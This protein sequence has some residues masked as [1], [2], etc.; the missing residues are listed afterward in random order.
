MAHCND[1]HTEF[2]FFHFVGESG[3]WRWTT[4]VWRMSGDLLKARVL[5]PHLIEKHRLISW[6]WYKAHISSFNL[7]SVDIYK[8]EIQAWHR[9]QMYN[10][11]CLTKLTI[12][13]PS[14]LHCEILNYS[15][16]LTE[17][18]P[19]LVHPVDVPA[20]IVL[21]WA[22]VQVVVALPLKYYSNENPLKTTKEE[23]LLNK[24]LLPPTHTHTH[25]KN[26]VVKDNY[27]YLFI[28]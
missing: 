6:T 13:K 2:E 28:F 19:G 23:T 3:C 24:C 26:V 18:T 5:W 27:G 8:H 4:F 25:Q 7:V 21:G 17:N 12:W 11:K 22:T 14:S 1:E 9:S 20:L 15:W 10:L 16:V